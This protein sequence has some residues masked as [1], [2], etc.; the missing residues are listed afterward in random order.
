MILSVGF[1]E[2]FLSGIINKNQL[3]FAFFIP[4]TIYYGTLSYIFAIVADKYK[5]RTALIIYVIGGIILEFV[6]FR[7]VTK[8]TDLIFYT[9]IYL[10]IFGT[11]IW[12][13]KK[14]FKERR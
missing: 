6:L 4:Y 3:P 11:P 5:T 12:L 13:R 10:F 7:D 9:F 14:F 1:A 2:L 8:F